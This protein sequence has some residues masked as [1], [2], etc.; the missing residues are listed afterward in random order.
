[1]AKNIGPYRYELQKKLFETK[2]SELWLSTIRDEPET[3]VVV[4][5]A[6]MSEER[7]RVANQLAIPNEENWLRKLDH[8]N[9][10]KLLPIANQRSSAHKIYRA[11]AALSNEPWFVVTEYFSG[12]TLD[13]WLKER[14]PIP[15]LLILQTIASVAKTLA[16]VHSKECVHRDIK[17]N[18]IL[19]R[20]KP[21][22]FRLTP[23][24]EPVLIDFGIAR[25]NQENDFVYGASQWLPPESASA[26]QKGRRLPAA[27]SMD[28][29]PLGLIL[30]A[31][32]TRTPR[33]PTGTQPK[34]LTISEEHLRDQTVPPENRAQMVKGVNQLL[35]QV[36]DPTPGRRI[37]IQ[38]MASEIESRLLP[39]CAVRKKVTPKPRQFGG[40]LAAVLGMLSILAIAIFF[41][42]KNEGNTP[43]ATLTAVV[44]ITPSVTSV[45][46]A[47]GD[48]TVTPVAPTETIADPPLEISTATDIPT[49][50]RTRTPTRQRSTPTPSR[51][52]VASNA[53][54]TST[55]FV[56]PTAT[57]S[58]TA[59]ATSEPSTATS[60]SAATATSLVTAT[61]RSTPTAAPRTA[62]P[63]RTVQATAT[64]RPGDTATVRPSDTPTPV[65]ATL[66][67]VVVSTSTNTSIPPT[68]VP[69]PPTPTY[70]VN[71]PTATSVPPTA[72]PPTSVPPTA[73]PPTS[74]PPTAVP[75][76]A[77]PPTST[78][79]PPTS[80]SVP[81]TS[82]SIP[83][84]ATSV[85][86]TAVPP[87]PTPIPPTS[88]FTPIPPTA[89][90]T[91]I[92]PTRIPTPTL[93]PILPTPTLIPTVPTPTLIPT[94]RPTS[95]PTLIPSSTPTRIPTSTPTRIPLSTP[96]RISPTATPRPSTA[97]P[98]P[99]PPT[100]TR[101]PPT[102]IPSST[103]TP[104]PPTPIPPTPIPPTPIPP[105][106]VLTPTIG[107]VRLIAPAP[108]ATGSRSL[109]FSWDADFRLP[110]GY[111]FELVFWRE[112]EDPFIEGRSPREATQATSITVNLIELYA[113]LPGPTILRPGRNYWGVLVVE[114]NPYKRIKIASPER[115][116]NFN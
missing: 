70:T 108:D 44:A 101:I 24:T 61:P 115:T 77:V 98:T 109:T 32:L 91:P 54:P 31:L 4:K 3:K 93:I 67:P 71:P 52:E 97:T 17:P 69:A 53:V 86:P 88:T 87:T 1:M 78:S 100:P 111:A 23:E 27:F 22:G 72:V 49:V 20:Q 68:P 73:V 8:P 9:I 64:P 6:R 13:D 45:E 47:M 55:P 28:T 48:D 38:R 102:P 42:F 79:I 83:P 66:A 12:G 80:T 57:P 50:T 74:V 33:P 76:T 63:T 11:R 41:V 104:I 29:Y 2:M 110:P 65:P 16:F 82:T 46:I 99:I 113:S 103:P 62:T 85:P 75:P 56:R 19:F 81:P 60:T 107:S 92:P 105:T 36:L 51:T 116:F 30:Y 25:R 96:M 112:G 114:T 37:S 14:R 58:P 59:S 21:S 10:I 40:L 90:N 26:Q 39:L 34:T 106:P 94:P 7:F 35:A 84:T 89:T 95:T 5:I 18:N 43:N 15:T